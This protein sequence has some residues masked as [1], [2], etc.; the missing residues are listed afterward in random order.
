LTY[1]EHGEH[2][3]PGKGTTIT[4]A[5]VTGA[6]PAGKRITAAALLAMLNHAVDRSGKPKGVIAAEMSIKAP[7]L[8]ALLTGERPWTLE[9]VVQ[10]P[11]DVRLIFLRS[12]VEAEGLPSSIA[13]ALRQL[14]DA[15]DPQGRLPLIGEARKP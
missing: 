9:R 6:V 13:N 5:T 7:R 2:T 11:D 12:W 4:G 1:L 8:T 3:W 10:L 14:A 15:M